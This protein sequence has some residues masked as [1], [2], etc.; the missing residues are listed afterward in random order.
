MNNLTRRDM[1]RGAAGFAAASFLPLTAAR[2]VPA[3]L[4]LSAPISVAKVGL[5]ARD[6]ETV[7]RWYERILGLKRLPASGGSIVLGADSPLLEIVETTGLQ[8]APPQEAG[9]YHTAF[10]LPARED[11]ARWVLHASSA[12]FPIDGVADHLVS[13]A[14][15]LTDPEGNGVEIY[16]DRPSESWEWANGQVEMASLPIDFAGLMDTI[17]AGD[18]TWS[19]APS[20]TS[21]GHVHLKVGDSAKAAD[22]WQDSLDFDIVRSR[23]GAAFLSTGGYH[24]HV[25]VNQWQSAGAARR[26]PN[27]TGLAYVELAARDSSRVGILADDWGTEIRLVALP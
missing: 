14:I 27:M 12:Q 3:G 20:G 24:H 7:A 16:A 13:E 22:W 6:A 5:V 17:I 10:L 15:Y 11:L 25:A 18:R 2:A 26:M 23:Q 21:V 19:G 1:L 8:L 9:L 4:P